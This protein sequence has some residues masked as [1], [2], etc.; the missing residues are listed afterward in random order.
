MCEESG[1]GERGKSALFN[2]GLLECSQ[3]EGVGGMA[4]SPPSFKDV[5]VCV[6]VCVCTR[7]N[8]ILQSVCFVP[9]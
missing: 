8:F 2:N 4:F 1:G 9:F 6:S 3:G 7:G 5:S